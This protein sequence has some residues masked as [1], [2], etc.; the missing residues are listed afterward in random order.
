[1]S[2]R[3]MCITIIRQPTSVKVMNRRRRSNRR[4][5]CGSGREDGEGR[6]WGMLGGMGVRGYMRKRLDVANRVLSLLLMIFL[7]L[8]VT[9]HFENEMHLI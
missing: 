5:C 8:Y 1:M 9:G 4:V 7:F 3:Y 2:G 6:G